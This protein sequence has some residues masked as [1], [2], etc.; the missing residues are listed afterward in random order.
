MI[1]H[2]ALF[3]WKPGVSAA[4]EAQVGRLLTGLKARIPGIVSASFG[5]QNSPE[6]LGKGMGVGLAVVFSDAAARDAY[7][8]HPAHQEVVAALKPLL[9][10]L[11]VLDYEF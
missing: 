7:L 11:V 1:H 9:A 2:I 8:P 3:Q 5:R 10:D 4:Q 6:G